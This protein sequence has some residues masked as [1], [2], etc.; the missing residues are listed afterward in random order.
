MALAGLF[1]HNWRPQ[2][3][4]HISMPQPQP[5]Y[6]GTTLDQDKRV[7]GS[8]PPGTP[9]HILHGAHVVYTLVTCHKANKLRRKWCRQPKPGRE[10]VVPVGQQ[11]HNIR[12]DATYRLFWRRAGNQQMQRAVSILLPVMSCSSQISVTVMTCAYL[13]LPTDDT[14]ARSGQYH[15]NGVLIA[16]GGAEGSRRA[17]RMSVSSN[18]WSPES[19]F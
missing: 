11:G 14:L 2:Q 12:P 10:F 9:L 16:E 17:A 1:R 6:S 7:C 3:A 15:L 8:F 13:R 18:S 5:W 19:Q 4:R